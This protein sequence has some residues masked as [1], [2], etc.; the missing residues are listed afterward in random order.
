MDP[1]I[2]E[3][4]MFGGTFAPLGWADCNGQLMAI[5]QN[6]A[7]FALIGTTFGGDGQTTFALPDLRSRVPI[8][9]GQGPGLTNRNLG[10]QGGEETVT[11][12]VNQLPRHIHTLGASK[13][14]GNSVSPQ[15]AVI[16]TDPGGASAGFSTGGTTNVSLRAGVVSQ[17]G[18]NVP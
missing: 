1:F 5:S 9:A 12:T 15:G 7:L 13:A 18:G 17:A 10:D 6:T 3:I 4:R 2:G 8:H 14:G 11:L 16:S